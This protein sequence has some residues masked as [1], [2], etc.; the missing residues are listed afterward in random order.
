[1][2]ILSH[3]RLS[4]PTLKPQQAL[5]FLKRKVADK[6]ALVSKETSPSVFLS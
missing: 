4:R 5:R 3:A 6:K 1:M 2:E